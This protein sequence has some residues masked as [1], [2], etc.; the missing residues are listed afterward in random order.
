MIRI[1]VVE[2]HPVMRCGYASLLESEPDLAICGATGS[3]SEARRGVAELAPDL[4]IVDLSLEEGSGLSLTED[5]HA[6]DPDRPI[7]VVSMHDESIFARRVLEAGAAGYLM[8]SEADSTIVEAIRAVV[9]HGFYLSSRLSRTFLHTMIGGGSGES[10][11]PLASLSARELEV[12]M[13]MGQGLGRR[14]IAQTLNLSPNTVDTHR[15]NVKEKLSIDTN[16][17]L[18]RRATIWVELSDGPGGG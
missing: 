16:P 10:T 6:A 5:L 1:F 14:E 18:M 4:V 7:L 11:S 13:L 12:F 15:E 8:K 2:D 3:A 17:Q 9:D